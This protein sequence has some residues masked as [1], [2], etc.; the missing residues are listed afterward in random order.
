MLNTLIAQILDPH[1]QTT[2]V[3]EASREII[4]LRLLAH[5]DFEIAAGFRTLDAMLEKTRPTWDS[6]WDLRETPDAYNKLI[7]FETEHA[8]SRLRGLREHRNK[9]EE[10]FRFLAQSPSIPNDASRWRDK[11]TKQRPDVVAFE[12]KYLDSE[13][14][15]SSRL[16]YDLDAERRCGFMSELGKQELAKRV[17]SSDAWTAGVKRR[18]A[19]IQHQEILAM[20]KKGFSKEDQ[21]R[22]ILKELSLARVE[23]ILHD[24]FQMALPQ[25]LPSVLES[26]DATPKVEGSSILVSGQ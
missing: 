16:S 4:D 18:R 17:A 6:K 9:A 24:E 22:G 20:E 12:I 26:D 2:I 15:S 21:L 3:N 7:Q 11:A 14:F 13:G 25:K 5:L 8:W 19:Q 10:L 23:S 1:G